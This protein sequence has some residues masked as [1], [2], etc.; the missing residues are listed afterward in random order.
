MSLLSSTTESK[1]KNYFNNMLFHHIFLSDVKPGD[2]LYRWRHFKL[3]QG[4]A[5][6]RNDDRSKM[7]VVM[8]NGLNTIRLVTLREFK[9]RGILR[10]ALYD[11]GDSNLHSIKLSGTSFIEKKISAEEIVQNALLLLDTVNRNPEYV[12][13]LFAHGFGDFARLCCT[14]SH[15]QWRN[16]LQR[17]GKKT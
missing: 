13:Q 7:F 10:R 11:Q 9:G 15:E 8:S 14:I 3:L 6:Q 1:I 4:I 16:R 2:H 17:N 5:V 12:Q